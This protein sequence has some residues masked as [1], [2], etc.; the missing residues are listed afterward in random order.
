MSVV[1]DIWQC[2]DDGEWHA[3]ADIGEKLVLS[4]ITVHRILCFLLKYDFVTL[5][6]PNL[7]VKTCKNASLVRGLN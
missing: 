6:A 1:D 7:R 4:V 2:L 3:A 5:D